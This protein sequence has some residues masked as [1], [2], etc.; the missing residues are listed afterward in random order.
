MA[1]KTPTVVIYNHRFSFAPPTSG[2]VTAEMDVLIGARGSSG[3]P[4]L[5][6]FS[7]GTDGE[8]P[9]SLTPA[10]TV[11]VVHGVHGN[12][13]GRGPDALP[14][15]GTGLAQLDVLV[16]SVGDLPNGGRAAGED[17]A[18]LA[19]GESDNDVPISTC[20]NTTR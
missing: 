16:L 20:S 1:Q 8:A 17:L 12:A 3:A 18:L 6:R 2:L 5:R 19:R 11:G 14:S 9:L 4:A 7:P 13:P 10:T 15:I